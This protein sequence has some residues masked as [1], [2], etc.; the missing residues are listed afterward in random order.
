MPIEKNYFSISPLND[1]PLQSAGANGVE[2]GFSFK[3]SNPI[4]KFSLPAI[5]KLL[6]VNSLVLSGQFFIKDSSTNEG[7]GRETNY[8]NINNDNG[9]NMTPETAIN[10]P[11][12]GGVHNVIDKVVIQTKK[13]N[14]ELVNIHNYSSYASLREAYTNNDEDYLW[15][16]APNRSLALGAHANHQNRLMNIVADKTKQELKIN[17]NKE[18]GVHFSIKL[19]IDMLQSGNIHLG[20]AYTNGLLLTLHLAPDSAVLHNRF[21]DSVIASQVG[22]DTRN[23]MYCL[24]N[25]KL[26]GRYVIPTPQELSAYPPN[27][28]M[29][30]QINLL[31]DLHAD[32]DNNTYTPQLNSVKAMCNLYLDKDQTNNLNYQ[33]NNFRFPVG[34]K[35]IEHKK[36]NLRFPFTFPLK[37]Q[38][39][40]ESSVELGTGAINMSQ[41]T[42]YENNL[43]DIELR[44]HFER[45]LLGG[46]E[47][48]KSSAT[49]QRSQLNQQADYEDRATNY[50]GTGSAGGGTAAIANTDGVGSQMFPELLGLGVD[51]TYGIG[52]SMAYV[53]R[54]YSNT[55]FSGVNAGNTS[56]PVDRRNKSELVQSFVKYNSVLNLKTL[57]KTM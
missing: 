27:L 25:L 10:I 34:M 12:H 9:A 31:N 42:Q 22:A 57:V 29:N 36:D 6:E 19:D 24:R 54:D 44:K 39:N 52:N 11:N 1:N 49:L 18:I 26:E 37:A 43:G 15:G 14:T 23:K 38:P 16:V 5:E 40:F 41:M 45:A 20:S 2:G 3:E 30:S 55:V 50:R 32:E 46:K 33:Q 53:N 7:F 17:N 28:M 8:T 48:V 56:L 4:V 35:K 21:R 51:Y 13:T 47:A